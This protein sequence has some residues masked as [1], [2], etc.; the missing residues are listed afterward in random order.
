[1]ADTDIEIIGTGNI[2][3]KSRQLVEKTSKLR[4]IGFYTPKRVVLAEGFFDGF[5]RRNNLGQSLSSV[6][7]V[8]DLEEKISMGSLTKEEFE[9]LQRIISSYG[10]SPLA[11][12]SSAQGDSRGTGIYKSVFTE[13]RISPVRRSLQE[14]LAGYFS[15]D[16]VAFRKDAK[17]GEGFGIQI[18]PIVGQ[19]IDKFCFCPV[20]SGFGYT[21]ALRGDGY[22]AVVPGLGGGVESRSVEK[23]T[24]SGIEEFDGRLSSYV[25]RKRKEFCVSFGSNLG[26]LKSSYLVGVDKLSSGDLQDGYTANAFFI[27]TKFQRAGVHETKLRFGGEIHDLYEYINMLP[28]FDMMERM[29]NAFGRPQYFEWAATV[30]NGN[31]MYWI[32]QIADVNEKSD[33]L[34]FQNLGKIILEAHTVTS[35][36]KKECQ[37][38]ALCK[39]SVLA[40][41]FASIIATTCQQKGN[42]NGNFC[43]CPFYLHAS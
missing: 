27:A 42:C 3:D 21:S 5:F 1:M 40:S 29:E 25:F 9:I 20:I 43:Y 37:K 16:S 41:Q 14:V 23:I 33:D 38:M 36:G 19:T 22:V 7:L 18:E 13:N 8:P 39:K 26:T 24:R 6:E 12:R 11:M 28:I 15:P 4:E 31:Q 2:G 35:T 10:N 17:T 30:I 34:D 32:N